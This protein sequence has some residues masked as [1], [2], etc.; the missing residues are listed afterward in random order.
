MS[1]LK[2][3]IV[4][5]IHMFP[6][7]LRLSI[8][9][10]WTNASAGA[11]DKRI[12]GKHLLAYGVAETKEVYKWQISVCCVATVLFPPFSFIVARL[13]VCMH[14]SIPMVPWSGHRVSFRSYSPLPSA[15]TVPTE[16]MSTTCRGF[17]C[18]RSLSGAFL[19]V[20]TSGT[21]RW[22]ARMRWNGKKSFWKGER[23]CKPS[24]SV[25]RLV[26]YATVEL[27]WWCRLCLFDCVSSL[28]FLRFW[29]V[30]A[31]NSNGYVHC[32]PLLS[33]IQTVYASTY[34]RITCDST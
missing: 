11:D 22:Y 17:S 16:I 4:W 2:K 13:C 33:C 34:S 32:C 31:H 29:L 3:V 20:S 21:K 7:P 9:N 14:G 15:A 8:V 25:H 27:E 23:H 18:M 30:C 26:W 6:H 5:R 10:R 19:L 24:T 28:V 1:C 12:I